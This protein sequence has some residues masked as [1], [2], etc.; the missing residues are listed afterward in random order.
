MGME[1][2]LRALKQF[3]FVWVLLGLLMFYVYS[4]G[5]GSYFLLVAGNLLVEVLLV[6]YVRR[7]QKS[8][9]TRES[10]FNRQPR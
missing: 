2:I 9:T 10:R 7:A 5:M 6:V 1:R 4:V 3:V 8:S